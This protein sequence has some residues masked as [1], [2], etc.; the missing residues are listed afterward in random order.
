M[1]IFGLATQRARNYIKYDV[2]FEYIVET[3]AN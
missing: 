3:D 1:T 2:N